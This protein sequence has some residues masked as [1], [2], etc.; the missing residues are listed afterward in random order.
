MGLTR[1]IRLFRL[2]TGR[3]TAAQE[4]R[5]E[6]AL[7]VD[8]LTQELVDSGL[9]LDAARAEAMRRMGNVDRIGR[10]VTLRNRRNERVIRVGESLDRLARD[11]RLGVR[12]LA[13]TPGFTVL[14]ILA[15]ALG[16]GA[17]TTVFSVFNAVILR[18]FPYPDTDRLAVVHPTDSVG[19]YTGVS[20]TTFR[21][22]ERGTDKLLLLAAYSG[23]AA[24]L[25]A[26][27]VPR[28][29]TLSRVSAGFFDVMGLG[30]L[31]GR[32]WNAE[33]GRTAAPVAVIGERL[34]R[35]ESGT[36]PGV[37]GRVIRLNG[38]PTTVV[39]VMPAA[40]QFPF[41]EQ[42]WVPYQLREP[43][44]FRRSSVVV[45]LRPEISCSCAGP[46]GRRR[47]SVP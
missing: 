30:P 29:V 39:G 35:R 14:A 5:D 8:L 41:K 15:F 26:G 38:T 43:T 21:D 25:S 12:C 24:S 1:A 11:L 46:R 47:S 10:E 4:I 23:D 45:R 3:S 16:I 27:E 28:R 34:W 31:L 44:G 33:E 7:H 2:A 17:S 9:P 13:R 42:V 6:L 18:P 22:W 36:D 20:E 37:V 32:A 19:Q 40:F